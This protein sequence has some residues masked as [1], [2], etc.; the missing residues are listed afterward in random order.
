MPD[1]APWFDPARLLRG[2]FRAT[3][4]RWAV[5]SEFYL[6]PARHERPGYWRAF[7]F[8]LGWLN[9]LTCDI[10][11]VNQWPS[12]STKAGKRA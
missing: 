1:R 3:W 4:A 11:F 6:W 2:R 9:G 7:R 10:R 8:D 5:Y 12:R